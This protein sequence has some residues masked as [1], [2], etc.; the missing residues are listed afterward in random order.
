MKK[1]LITSFL[2]LA[3]VILFTQSAHAAGL[4][5]YYPLDSDIDDH[6]GSANLHP[7]NA[8]TY[9]SGYVAGIIDG[10]TGAAFGSSGDDGL[11]AC[12]DIDMDYNDVFS[13]SFWVNTTTTNSDTY[14][15][16]GRCGARGKVSIYNN[17][18]SDIWAWTGAGAH[19]L[20]DNTNI[21]DGDTHFIVI[22]GDGST[23]RLYVDNVLKDSDTQDQDTSGAEDAFGIGGSFQSGN[24]YSGIL[25]DVAIW[26]DT[27]DATAIS[28]LWNGGAGTVAGNGGTISTIEFQS[29][30]DGT[31][32]PDFYFW[33]LNLS[34][35]S[36]GDIVSVL[37]FNADATS[38]VYSD[39]HVWVAGAEMADYLLP[40]TRLLYQPPNLLETTWIAQAYLYDSARTLKATS[41]YI[42]FT[43]DGQRT[44]TFTGD[45]IGQYASSTAWSQLSSSTLNC[46]QYPFTD[47]YVGIPFFATSSPNRVG[48][49]I[50]AITG[51]I[52]SFMFVPDATSTAQLADRIQ[53]F[54]QVVPGSVFFTMYDAIYGGVTSSTDNDLNVLNINLPNL[55]EPGDPIQYTLASSSTI[56]DALTTDDCNSSCALGIREYWFDWIRRILYAAT[57]IG[58]VLIIAG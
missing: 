29:P 54:T 35:V 19:Y 21:A 39:E 53:S 25:D 32:I 30:V 45:P 34:G 15:I 57:T 56:T 58:S 38:S 14:M 20:T 12:S 22:T 40:K 36:N 6:A 43:I 13:I 23:L 9:P 50:L 3:G 33:G 7:G 5:A 16:N 41:G 47:T 18:A 4:R 2:A 55:G 31:T 42:D 10:S 26:D 28:D 51:N 49:E 8:G 11:T 1:F 44:I 37:Y 24:E 48:C 27:I 46:A 17:G 52:L